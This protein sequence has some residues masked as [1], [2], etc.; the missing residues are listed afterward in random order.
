MGDVPLET[1]RQRLFDNLGAFVVG[2]ATREAELIRQLPMDG[3]ERRLR[4]MVAATRCTEVDEIH[5]PSCTT[6]GSVVVPVAL[7]SAAGDDAVL[8]GIVAGYE[9]MIRLGLSVDGAIKLY[10]GVWPTYL[11]APF[12]AAA[13]CA[14][15]DGFD[16]ERTANA[17]SIALSRATGIT[18]RAPGPRSPRWFDIG[19]AAV[20]GYLAAEAAGI[21]MAGDSNLLEHGFGRAVRVE[22]DDS[23]F[24][25]D[26]ARWL[27]DD[28]DS[29]PFCTARQGLAATEA[30]LRLVEEHPGA[31]IASVT[32]WVP[33]QVRNM[34][35]APH[36]PLGLPAQFALAVHD[37]LGLWD[38]IRARPP[39][40][41]KLQVAILEDD[42]YTGLFPRVW[43][44][45]V[46]VGWQDG[47]TSEREV[48]AARRLSWDEL[49]DKQ[50]QIADACGL[51]HAWIEP[52]SR[53]CRQMGSGKSSSQQ[54]LD[55]VGLGG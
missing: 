7:L 6:V 18:A 2:A 39:A 45:R 41:D 44:G 17:L 20:D 24:W 11:T 8:K 1:A 27:I 19:C 38:V 47:T 43:A 31:G 54:L 42:R 12:A 48:T 35:D 21:G 37:R 53:L 29:K 33:G 3:P 49:V 40:H 5:A 10:D 16:A 23:A 32:A 34:V 28:V 25:A 9:A 36:P 52:A 22:F 50:H 55:L 13:T 14:A 51:S 30:F 26:K 46:A 15:I 4:Y